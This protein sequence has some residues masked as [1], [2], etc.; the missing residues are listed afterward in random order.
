[1]SNITHETPAADAQ[2]RETEA[3]SAQGVVLPIPRFPSRYASPEGLPAP[4]LTTWPTLSG[5]P[6]DVK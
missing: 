6:T 5:F 2:P 1:M 3:N 4:R